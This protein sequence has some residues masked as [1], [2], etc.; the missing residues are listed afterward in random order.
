MS[1]EGSTN[2]A[3]AGIE[4]QD[5]EYLRTVCFHVGSVSNLPPLPIIP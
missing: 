4:R 1:F 5:A 2:S 3:K